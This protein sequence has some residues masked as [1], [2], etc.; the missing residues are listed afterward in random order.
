MRKGAARRL[1]DAR[2]PVRALAPLSRWSGYSPDDSKTQ[3]V[4][5][6]ISKLIIGYWTLD[7]CIWSYAKYASPHPTSNTPPHFPHR[8]VAAAFG[9]RA[10]S[11]QPGH[12]AYRGPQL[13]GSGPAWGGR[14]TTD[15][16]PG[17]AGSMWRSEREMPTGRELTSSTASCGVSRRMRYQAP[18]RSWQLV[19]VRTRAQR[20]SD[21]DETSQGRGVRGRALIEPAPFSR[22]CD[23][24]HLSPGR[25]WL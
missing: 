9:K 5:R 7:I 11:R 24:R 21:M 16:T 4:Q 10:R 6:P 2:G 23:P 8:S 22:R 14:G 3:N 13:T 25:R 15:H 17:G 1:L 18:R 12:T 19:S 20:G